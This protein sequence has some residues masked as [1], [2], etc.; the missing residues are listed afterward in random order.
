LDDNKDNE[1]NLE[2]IEFEFELSDGLDIGIIESS[3]E[4]EDSVEFELGD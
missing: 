2:K 3:I 1:I 4:Q